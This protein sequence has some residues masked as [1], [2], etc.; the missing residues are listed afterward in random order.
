MVHAQ[1]IVVFFLKS[2]HYIRGGSC[3]DKQ[4]GNANEKQH[5]HQHHQ[6]ND[7]ACA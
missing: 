7:P 5:N 1:I 4:D 6:G 2:T 3:L